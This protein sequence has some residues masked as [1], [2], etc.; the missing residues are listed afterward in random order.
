MLFPPLP[1]LCHCIFLIFSLSVFLSLQL[2]LI[3]CKS[4]SV[5]CCS[6]TIC[7]STHSLY[8][9]VILSLYLPFLLYNL[10]VVP[11]LFSHPHSASLSLDNYLSLSLH[12]INSLCLFFFTIFIS[13][14]P[15]I[16]LYSGKELYWISFFL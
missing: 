3:L 12:H 4:F 15:P 8:V 6:S 16:F 13:R 9:T 2:P 14:Y 5:L 10:F 7:H 1:S 11:M